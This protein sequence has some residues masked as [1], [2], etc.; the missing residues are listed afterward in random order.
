M[1]P[2]AAYGPKVCQHEKDRFEVCNHR[3]TALSD[4]SHGVAVLNDCKYGISMLDN[5]LSL[6]LLRA[7]ESPD[8]TA[9]RGINHFTYAFVAY[10]GDFGTS[11]VVREGLDLNYEP[12]ITEGTGSEGSFFELDKENIILDTIKLAEDGS[13]DL[14]LRLYD[15]K[16]AA[17]RAVLSSCL[18]FGKVSECDMLE[19]VTK[20]LKLSAENGRSCVALDFRAFEVKTLRL[21][22]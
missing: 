1:P 2:S 20:E 18:T 6:T 14:I 16:K 8:P 4:A 21:G 19:N 7:P 13:G 15:S 5:T 22:K 9:D 11:P 17:G 10:E 3:Y 12:V